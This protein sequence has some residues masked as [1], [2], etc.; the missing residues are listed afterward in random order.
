MPSILSEGADSGMTLGTLR[1]LDEQGNPTPEAVAIDN[2]LSALDVSALAQHESLNDIAETVEDEEGEEH[3]VLPLELALAAIDESDLEDMFIN[4]LDS[5]PEGTLAEKAV[6]ASLLEAYMDE[7]GLDE[8]NK[9]AIKA[10][11]AKSGKAA[12][13]LKSAVGTKGMA[14]GKLTAMAKKKKGSPEQTAALRMLLA[15]RKKEVIKYDSTSGHNVKD[16]GYPT[17]G[18]PA[19]IARVNKYKAAAGIKDAPAKKAKKV[20]AVKGGKAGK[21]NESEEMVGAMI[22]GLGE[23]IHGLTHVAAV[24]ET[25][26]QDL[27]DAIDEAKKKKNGPL[28]TPGPGPAPKKPKDAGPGLKAEAYEGDARLVEGAGLAGKAVKHL[29]G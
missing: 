24:S 8:A 6:K 22:F 3:T 17:G 28:K 12:K 18:T 2:F 1:L 21:K 5:L 4:Y 23:P 16:V 14:R 29:L 15:M 10:A 25:L 13:A 11:K 9:A 19:G 26:D 20:K 27:I 7:A